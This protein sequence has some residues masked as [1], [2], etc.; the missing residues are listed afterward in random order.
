M[1]GFSKS[2][3]LYRQKTHVLVTSI[4]WISRSVSRRLRLLMCVVNLIVNDKGTFSKAETIRIQNLFLL[5]SEDAPIT[6]RFFCL[7]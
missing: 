5:I 1:P 3:A 7:M 4:H 6:F 2:I